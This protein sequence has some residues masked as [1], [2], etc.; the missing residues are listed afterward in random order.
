MSLQ[1]CT[2]YPL[3]LLHHNDRILRTKGII[4]IKFQRT[5][6]LALSKRFLC[7]PDPLILYHFLI[8]LFRTIRI[9]RGGPI[10]F[11]SQTF[12]AFLKRCLCNP[13]PFILCHFFIALFR[14]S[15]MHDPTASYLL[16]IFDDIVSIFANRRDKI[17]QIHGPTVLAYLK[18]YLC[19]PTP[20][21]L[22]CFYITLFDILRIK[23]VIPITCLN[24]ISLLKR[25]LDPLIFP[26]VFIALFRILPIKGVRPIKLYGTKPFGL[27]EEIS[28]QPCSSYP[29]PLLHRIVPRFPNQREN[30][31]KFAAK[32]SWLT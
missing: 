2:S 4:P 22:F 6:I 8:A 27:L 13:A 32:M 29:L 30:P 1:P 18:R 9:K 10:K 31:I 24:Y 7:K 26:R 23:G 16:S 12:L 25:C 17:N 19:I 28:L 15:R 11:H 21:V 3:S 14:I 5:T 20:L